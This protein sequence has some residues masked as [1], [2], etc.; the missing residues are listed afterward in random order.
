MRQRVSDD[1]FIKNTYYSFEMLLVIVQKSI[2]SNV[3][4]TCEKVNPRVET[5]LQNYAKRTA[6][7][8]LNT[9][10]NMNMIM[11]MTMIMNTKKNMNKNLKF[12]CEC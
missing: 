10:V 9:N 4:L 3:S 12:G 11:I 2:H 5:H 1:R 8:N 7:T 6:N